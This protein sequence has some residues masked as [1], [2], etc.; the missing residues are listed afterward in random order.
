LATVC[1]QNLAQHSAE[2]VA[3]NDLSNVTD[4]DNT[5]CMNSIS[6]D[7]LQLSV[8]DLHTS[9]EPPAT[10]ALKRISLERDVFTDE[11]HKP[12]DAKILNAFNVFWKHNEEPHLPLLLST[13]TGDDK[14]LSTLMTDKAEEL[15]TRKAS[16]AKSLRN[17]WQ[18]GSFKELRQLGGFMLIV[19]LFIRPL[20]HH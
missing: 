14:R 18:T 1:L 6:N 10:P 5:V 11:D 8:R 20:C 7:F 4:F 3:L 15:L 19:W 13:I 12:L 17:A 2:T 16:I 9:S